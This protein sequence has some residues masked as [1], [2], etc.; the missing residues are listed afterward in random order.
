ML[1]QQEVELKIVSISDTVQLEQP[2]QA[3]LKLQSNVDRQLGPLVLAMA[4][5]NDSC[6]LFRVHQDHSTGHHITSQP[7]Y[8]HILSCVHS[9]V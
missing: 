3:T 5:G 4:P 7:S 6:C 1:V 2:F 8:N 9:A